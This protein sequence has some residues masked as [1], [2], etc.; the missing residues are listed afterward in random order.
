MADRNKITIMGLG[1]ILLGDEGFGVHFIRWFAQRYEMPSGV[2]IVEGGVLGYWL[3]DIICS[4]ERLI[5][6]DVVK[7]DDEPGSIFR[8][9]QKEL[10][11]YAPAPS[12]AHEVQFPDVLCK[13]EMLDESPEVI[14][15]CIIPVAYG[16]MDME[17]T[18]VMREKFP[19]IEELLLKELRAKGIVPQ[20]V[21]DA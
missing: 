10:E 5:V 11:L 21:A 18:P 14:F 15:L 20:K 1:N 13:A 9:T 19:I 7:A 17:L 2:E 12:S 3:L 8:F 4:C 6:I 16:D